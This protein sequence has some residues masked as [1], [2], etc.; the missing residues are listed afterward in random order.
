MTDGQ[1][2]EAERVAA[3][4]AEDA[5]AYA[6]AEALRQAQNHR[7]DGNLQADERSGR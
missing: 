1:P 2:T 7:D 6:A 3:M 4:H 5:D